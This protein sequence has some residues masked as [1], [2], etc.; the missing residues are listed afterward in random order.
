MNRSFAILVVLAQLAFCMRAVDCVAE[1]A[2]ATQPMTEQQK[3][4]S[5][6]ADLEKPD[7]D[8]SLALL[9]FAG[10]PEPTIAFLKDHLTPLTISA[11]DV[12][13]LIGDLGSDDDA[14]WKP[15]FEK[16]EYLDPR[17]A[18][19]LQTLMTDTNDPVARD[20]MIEVLGDREPD[21]L[22][23]R[24][25]KLRSAGNGEFNFFDGNAS[26]WAEA[27]VANLGTSAWLAKRKWTR[28]IR[29][30]VLLEH[31]GTPDAIAILK[32]MAGGNSDAGPTKAAQQA[33][34]KLGVA[35]N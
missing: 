27:K 35:G 12:N 20:R 28:A 11:E 2:P 33:L 13:K 16:L 23:G 31:I 34:V 21:S 1:D 7:P 10:K 30:I 17:L 22:R 3:L 14:V 15:A 29:G 9:N 5:W 19:D 25:V 24:G 6:W 8:A 18:I 4:E 26:W 32:D